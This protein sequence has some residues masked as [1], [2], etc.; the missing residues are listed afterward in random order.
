MK[1]ILAL[2]LVPCL[3]LG[4][5]FLFSGCAKRVKY[6]NGDAYS[7]TSTGLIE[8]E[9]TIHSVEI[10][11]EGKIVSVIGSL[12]TNTVKVAEDETE[13]DDKALH[14]LVE[15]G[16]LKIYP[17]ASG[18]RISDLSKSLI[19]QLP[20]AMANSLQSLKIEVKG[21]TKV[22]LSTMKPASLEVLAEDG[23]VSFENG[24]LDRVRVETVK[25]NLTVRTPK[26]T[27]FAFLSEVGNANIDSRLYG[28]TAVMHNENGTLTSG[29][30]MTQNGKIYT[31]GTQET[32]FIFD[33]E[34]KIHIQDYDILGK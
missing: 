15:E 22:Q 25:G 4:S 9:E 23:N 3:L 29:Y 14:Y 16:V 28:F 34:G 10:Y 30:D 11:W 12:L 2:I 19:L 13:D 6:D 20:L 5:L 33:T 26:V 31:Y 18:E 24:T 17:C 1:K 32:V 8:T 27:D 7:T 21:D